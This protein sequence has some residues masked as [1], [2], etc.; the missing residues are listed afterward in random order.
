ME[1]IEKVKL[2]KEEIEA[3]RLALEVNLK[4][5][6]HAFELLTKDGD[7]VLGF[8]KEPDR[9]VK[10][11]AIDISMQSFM[12]AGEILLKS[13]LIVDESDSRILSENPIHDK[14]YI[15]AVMKAQELVSYYVDQLK[16]S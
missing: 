5:E 15:G 13:S 11:R 16:K 3:K 12:Q 1:E 8:M 4:S 7:Q 6:V 2:S 14:I 10:M 9:I